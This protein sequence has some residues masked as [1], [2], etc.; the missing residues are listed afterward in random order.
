MRNVQFIKNSEIDPELVSVETIEEWRDIKGYEGLYQVSNLGRVKSLDNFDYGGKNN[1]KR[2]RKGKILKLHKRTDG[3][4]GV[5]LNKNKKHKS[6]QVHRLVAQAF[7]PNTDN[8]PHIDHINTIRTD[9]RVENLRWVTPKENCNNPL[10]KV[11]HTNACSKEE[12]RKLI[13]NR[14]KGR[15]L[16]KEQIEKQ[17][18]SLIARNLKGKNACNHK[19]IEQ[20]TK[21]G[22]L[23]KKW[24]TILQAS[25]ALNC[26]S[27]NISSCCQGKL[28]SA[29]GYI[30]KY[31]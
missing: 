13:S 14:L 18:N 12:Y 20:Y 15:K 6:C 21:D 25:I 17:R 31:A 3:G 4:L 22:V 16:S 19:E 11:H 23:I 5:G 1:S 26:Y 2:L 30:W 8:K 7:I 9:N 10:T 28:K 27:G 29:Y 24:D